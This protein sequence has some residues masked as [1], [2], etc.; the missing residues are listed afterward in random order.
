MSRSRISS[1]DKVDDSNSGGLWF[2][3]RNT[4]NVANDISY[5]LHHNIIYIRVTSK[6]I[7]CCLVVVW[8]RR[9]T[10]TNPSVMLSKWNLLIA[11]CQCLENGDFSTRQHL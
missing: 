1:V 3:S 8:V 9:L 11:V 2:E 7:I 6:I 4:T 10:C 5:I